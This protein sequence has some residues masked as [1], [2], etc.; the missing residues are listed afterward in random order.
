VQ[1]YV[2]QFSPIA[3]QR[4][5]QRLTR[6]ANSLAEHADRGRSIGRL[7]E[8]TVISPYL[9]RYRVTADTVYILRIR[10]GARLPT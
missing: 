8:L 9:V 3:A 10:H 4:L 7:R 5:A 1:S 6:A 2:G